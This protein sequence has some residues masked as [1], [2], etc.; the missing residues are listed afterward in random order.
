MLRLS[1]LFFVAL[2]LFSFT[3][4]S[5]EAAT[6]EVK[7]DKEKVTTGEIFTLSIKIKGSFSSPKVTLPDIKDFRVASQAQSKSYSFKESRPTT[8]LNFT[9]LLFAPEPGVFTIG[10]VIVED[11]SERITSDDITI[12][13]TGKPLKEKKPPPSIYH[14]G[15]DI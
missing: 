7:V 11:K 2:L 13:V 5:Q 6:I 9:Y 12:E 15:F 3:V 8:L 10:Q 4:C 14:R 1:S